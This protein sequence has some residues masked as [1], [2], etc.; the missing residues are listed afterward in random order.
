MSN[1]LQEQQNHLFK[2]ADEMRAEK[3]TGTSGSCSGHPTA[4]LWWGMAGEAM[5]HLIPIY[6]AEK[7]ASQYQFGIDSR[8]KRKRGKRRARKETAALRGRSRHS[9]QM[10]EKEGEKRNRK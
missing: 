8:S 10:V 1:F 4:V 7:K 5:S 2:T 6:K 3:Q 9:R